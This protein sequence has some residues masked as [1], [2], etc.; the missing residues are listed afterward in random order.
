[1]VTTQKVTVTKIG[2]LE[3]SSQG[4]ERIALFRFLF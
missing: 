3:Q 4:C 1:M 2:I